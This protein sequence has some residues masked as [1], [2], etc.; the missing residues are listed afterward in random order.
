MRA[1]N[2]MALLALGQTACF[3]TP[4]K[5]YDDQKKAMDKLNQDSVAAQEKALENS[6]TDYYVIAPSVWF[7]PTADGA[8]QQ[9]CADGKKYTK[10][11]TVKV[12]GRKPV[13]GLWRSAVYGEKGKQDGFVL[14]AGVNEAPDESEFV[15]NTNKLDQGLAQAKRLPPGYLNL[16][17]LI[18]SSSTLRGRKVLLALGSGEL[19]N[20]TTEGGVLSFTSLIPVSAGSQAMASIQFN[21]KSARWTSDFNSG[22]KSFS[23]GPGHCDKLSLVATLTGKL[24]DR[25]DEYGNAKKLPIFEVERLVDRFGLYEKGR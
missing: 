25:V 16:S 8:R 24:A 18:A 12:V 14:A 9:K 11:E 5:G 20:M 1:L 15:A 23:C 19:R 13:D 10:G 2:W 4:H 3:L 17:D 6:Q 7:C 22:K 21:F